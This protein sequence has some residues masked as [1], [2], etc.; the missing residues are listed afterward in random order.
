MEKEEIDFLISDIEMPEENG[1]ELLSWMQEKGM[2]T[3][4]LLLTSYADFHYAKAAIDYK[5]SQYLLKPIE[6]SKLEEVMIEQVDSRVKYQREKRLLQC[7]N[8]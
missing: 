2:D 6:T 5:C 4:K 3:Q 7:G 1:F 8:D